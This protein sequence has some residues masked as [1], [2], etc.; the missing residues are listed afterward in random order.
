LE[1]KYFDE[2][3]STQKFLLELIK[4]KKAKAPLAVICNHQTKG[5][6]S[7]GNSWS[8]KRGNF[9]ASIAL[10][11]ESLPLDLELES[12]SIYFGWLMIKVLRSFGAKVWLKWPND[13][14][15]GGEKVGGV[16]T[17]YFQK[18]FVV[19]IGVNL[20]DTDKFKGLNLNLQPKEIL[21]E[22]IKI[23]EKSISWEEVFLEFSKEFQK[24]KKFLIHS[25][26]AKISL[27]D[28]KL[29]KDGSLFVDGK[30]IFS[31]R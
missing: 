23:L 19:G 2:L 20:K 24:S 14:F 5:V 22:Y 9:F 18:T 11:K 6:G 3:D 27:K 26:Q 1:I 29:F 4:K 8:G 12:A 31:L 21:K 16:I 25:N 30:R 28:A 13:I 7:R 10:E 15:L 17:N